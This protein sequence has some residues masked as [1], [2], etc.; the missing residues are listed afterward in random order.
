MPAPS[1]RQ[2]VLIVAAVRKRNAAEKSAIE[3]HGPDF[4]EGV[5]RGVGDAE[6]APQR[7]KQADDQRA[8]ATGESMDPNLVADDGELTEHRV[9]DRR[10][11]AVIALQD[12][13]QHRRHHEQQRKQR[14]E[15]VVG[16]ERGQAPGLVVAELAHD[17]H[18]QR[19]R[20]VAL[21]EE[22]EGPHRAQDVHAGVIPA[23]AWRDSA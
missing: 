9:L 21:L 10:L 14:E 12:E 22:V 16:D 17:R 2:L 5:L 4:V 6:A 11:R 13:A 7:A 3:R 15:A 23:A 19:E 20:A 1:H 8:D 18:R